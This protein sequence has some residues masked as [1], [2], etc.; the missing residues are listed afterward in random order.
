[1][2]H[3]WGI[4]GAGRFADNFFASAIRQAQNAR[5]VAVMARDKS[6]AEAFSKKHNARQF[7]DS[8]EALCKEGD[9]DLVYISSPT[10]LHRE[11][12]VTAA[13]YGKHVLCEK[14]M[15]PTLEEC[16]QMIDSC[17]ENNVTLAIAH[18]MRFH[19][20]HQEVKN[21][22]VNQKKV[23]TVGLVRAEMIASFKKNQGDKYT[24]DQFRLNRAISGG[25]VMFDMGIHTIDLLRYI[26]DDEIEEIT[27]FSQN[28]FT[29]C[30]GEDTV[31]A[32]FR[33][34]KGA[35]GSIASSG[36][37]PYSR[38]GVDIYGDKGAIFTD[39]SVWMNA[40][41]GEIKLF[42]DDK[43]ESYT[44]ETNNC[45]VAEVEHF[46]QCVTEKRIPLVDGEEGRKNIK[47]I[48]A[49]YQSMD[50]GRTI[51]IAN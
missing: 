15:A 51:R 35:Y 31:S 28:L 44:T 45:Y 50:E 11:H 23:G 32:V 4:I 33:F 18:N 49:F 19:K 14:P 22:V 9:V 27:G 26:L 30:N 36:A 38:N 42:A 37:L 7:F 48:L 13:K 10:I 6:K 20:V 5:L 43:W 8:A 46:Q 1:M 40:R 21:M 47:V 3:K 41:T 17:K 24:T 29:D 16:D 2:E 25:G 34:N 12:T 39:G